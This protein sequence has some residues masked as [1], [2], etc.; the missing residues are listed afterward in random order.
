MTYLSC[1]VDD[2]IRVDFNYFHQRIGGRAPLKLNMY[3]C[4]LHIKE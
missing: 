4:G 1:L 3:L 2:V